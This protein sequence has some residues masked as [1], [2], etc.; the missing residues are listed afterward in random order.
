M[1]WRS[2]SCWG[3]LVFVFFVPP[4]YTQI[5]NCSDITWLQILVPVVMQIHQTIKLWLLVDL[6]CCLQVLE[7]LWC[8]GCQHCLLLLVESWCCTRQHL[9]RHWLC[10]SF[11]CS[12]YRF[13]QVLLRFDLIL[14]AQV[15]SV[16]LLGMANAKVPNNVFGYVGWEIRI[17]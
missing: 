13:Y 1:S 11:L 2:I 7:L 10:G 6:L 5:S 9:T 12:A 17:L 16:G 8:V 4:L 15:S 14:V 3:M